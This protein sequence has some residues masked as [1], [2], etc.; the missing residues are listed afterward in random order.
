MLD[1]T[2]ANFHISSLSLLISNYYSVGIKVYFIFFYVH[3]LVVLVGVFSCIQ[4]YGLISIACVTLNR[5]RIMI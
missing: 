1:S 5:R 3:V 4:E 2:L